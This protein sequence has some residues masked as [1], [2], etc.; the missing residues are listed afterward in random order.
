ME[1]GYQG[2]PTGGE[3]QLYLGGVCYPSRKH[4]A[5]RAVHRIALSVSTAVGVGKGV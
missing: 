1:G 2:R 3:G 4:Q 5:G